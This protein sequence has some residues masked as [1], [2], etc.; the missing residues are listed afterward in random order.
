MS[1]PIY[2]DAAAATP[3]H[4]RAAEAL[5]SALAAFGDPRAPHGPGRAARAV[6]ERA[7]ARVASAIGA[8][9]DEIIFCG[10][11][12]QANARAIPGTV[13]PDGPGGRIVTT[14]LEHPSVLEAAK[15]T[16]LDV[17]EVA[18][19]E[20]GRVDVDGFSAAVAVPGTAL[21]T[22]QHASQDTGSVN[23]LAECAGMARMAGAR[24]H[25]DASHTVPVLPVDVHALGVDLL[26]ISGRQAYAVPGVAALYARRGLSPDPLFRGE[27]GRGQAGPEANVPG[28]AALGAALEA[29]RPEIP[30]LAGRLWAL[31]GQLRE[32][33][34]GSG[35]GIRVLGHPTQRLPQIVSW[36]V[37]GIDAET[38]LM[39]LEDRGIVAGIA[40]PGP[41]VRAG[42]ARPGDVVVRMGLSR[43]T[44]EVHVERVL[45]VVPDVVRSLRTMAR[46][47]DV[48]FAR[49]EE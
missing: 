26:T 36:A 25:T 35:A 29:L 30:E 40:S 11:A 19:D 2:L 21:A 45:E 47:A 42:L 31:S 49:F 33:L 20:H 32:G 14:M 10:G 1:E 17:V 4:P 34:K 16:G 44:T 41:L 3:L 27:G 38:L 22:V 43:D 46:R 24:V 39:S 7:R 15:V 12:P 8:D 6:L 48:A 28:A 9:P 5:R 37:S 18:C 23:A 13:A